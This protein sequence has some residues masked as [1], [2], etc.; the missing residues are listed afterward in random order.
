[1]S[2]LAS[3]PPAHRAHLAELLR[4]VV[5]GVSAV[6]TDFCVYF[7]IIHFSPGF[8]PSIAKAISFIAGACISFVANRGFVFRA[9]G[10]ASK[11]IVPFTL[12][13]LVSLGL[14]NAVNFVALALLAPKVVAWFLATGTSTVS[15]FVGMKFIVFKKT[16][17]VSRSTK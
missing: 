5:V 8:S 3:T 11:Q 15:N 6:A 13:Y 2:D 1:M 16:E 14:N 4:F 7:A 17:N 9:E 10:R 12:L